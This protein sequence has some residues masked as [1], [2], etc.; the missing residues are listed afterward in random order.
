MIAFV[1]GSPVQIMRAVHMKMYYDLCAEDADIYVLHKCPGF[2]SLAARL[3]ETGLFNDSYAVNASLLKKHIVFKLLV[4]NS[5]LAKIIKCKK[6]NKLI[7]FNIEDEVAQAIFC[8]NGK[9]IG[10]EHHCVEDGPNIYQIYEPPVYKWYHP[11]KW[12]GWDRQ[13]YHITAWWTSCPEFIELPESFHTVKKKLFPIDCKDEEYVRIVNS[14][15]LYESSVLL[16]DADV[17]IMDE[18]H[19]EDGLMVEDSDVKLYEKILNQYPNRNFLVK[20]HPRT[21]HNRYLE[22]FSVMDKTNIPWE[23]YVL[24]REHSKKKD[25]IQISI[26]CGTML[27][28]RFMFGVEGK[29][30]ILAPLFYNKVQIP[31]NGIPR[32]SETETRKYERIKDLYKQPENFIIAYTEEDIYTALDVML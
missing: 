4:G 10:F 27:S 16:D 1:C 3:G 22:H 23:L 19:Y 7:T 14:I 15:F 5:K 21:K 12:L 25:L 6:Y 24:N 30:V 9:R 2:E 18:S 31:S 11:F 26:V 32:V 8:L 29:K 28:D 20:M 17:L 13:A